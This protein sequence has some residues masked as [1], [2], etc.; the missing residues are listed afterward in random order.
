MR[1]QIGGKFFFF[2]PQYSCGMFLKNDKM[3]LVCMPVCLRVTPALHATVC[4]SV[5]G[6]G[7]GEMD[8]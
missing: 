1:A 2:L 3:R 6:C 7:D 5:E 4:I 8:V